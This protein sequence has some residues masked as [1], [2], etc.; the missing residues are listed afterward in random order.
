VSL[1][2][3]TRLG[4]FEIISHIGA[5]DALDIYEALLGRKTREYV[6]P[7]ILALCAAALGRLDEAFRHCEDAINEKDVQFAVFHMWWPAFQPVRSD[8][9][10]PEIRRRFN[11]RS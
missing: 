3:G 5:G 7:F 8:P 1:A 4:P 11:L 9:R 2:A 6:P 10:F